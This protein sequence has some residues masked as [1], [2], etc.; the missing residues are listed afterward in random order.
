MLGGLQIKLTNDRLAGE[1]KR[2]PYLHTEVHKVRWFKEVLRIW[3]FYAFLISNGEGQWETSG[4]T[5]EF[6]EDREKGHLCK[7][8]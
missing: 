3:G 7:S 6:L 8:K 2:I 1:K 4:R 5:N